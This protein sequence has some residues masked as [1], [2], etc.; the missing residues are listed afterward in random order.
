MNQRAY[1]AFRFKKTWPYSLAILVLFLLVSISI[2]SNFHN[3]YSASQIYMLNNFGVTLIYMGFFIALV[4]GILPR[5]KYYSK[6]S[7]DIY[8]SLPLE[9]KS[10]FWIDCLFGF[11]QV[12]LPWALAFLIGVL[13]FPVSA[14]GQWIPADQ[15][16]YLFLF[17]LLSVMEGWLFSYSLATYAN[18]LL[19]SF[20]LIGLGT[21][22]PYVCS[23]FTS[24]FTII[25]SSWKR[26]PT[27]YFPSQMSF[28][29]DFNIVDGFHGLSSSSSYSEH[30]ALTPWYCY[31]VQALICAI[32]LFC[33]Y[34][35]FEQ[36]KAENAGEQ[37]KGIWGYQTWLSALFFIFYASITT[38]TSNGFYGYWVPFILGISLGYVIILCIFQRKIK[39]SKGSLITAGCVLVSGTV[40]G[41]IL[42]YYSQLY[43]LNH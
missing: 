37:A 24:S 27:D 35:H 29:N 20:L 23:M 12:F 16:G 41:F 17:G 5:N 26:D 33:A 38:T 7:V 9:R 11:L 31:F 34:E 14:Y 2:I 36:W 21:A 1:W 42:N 30:Y 40:T 28:I 25:N 6:R 19:D 22:F 32:F 3:Y 4:M 18:N 8:A 10:V 39:V 15:A 13:F 43:L